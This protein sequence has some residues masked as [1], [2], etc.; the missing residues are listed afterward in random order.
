[1]NP[2]K[3]FLSI[4]AAGIALTFVL[5]I[6]GYPTNPEEAANE[7]EAVTIDQFVTQ[8][9]GSCHGAD[10]KGGFGPSIVGLTL[11]KEE[12]IEILVNGQGT[13][14]PGQAKGNEE[15]VA[16]YLLTLNH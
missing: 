3:V 2:I 10:L 12:I 5:G 15:E 14:P 4:F 13:M 1:M 11:T 7:S 8:S 9:C 16:E 6:I